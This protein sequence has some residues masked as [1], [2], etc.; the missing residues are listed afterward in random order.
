MK[1]LSYSYALI[2]LVF[3]LG[4]SVAASYPAIQGIKIEREHNRAEIRKLDEALRQALIEKN[5]PKLDEL[6]ADDAEI[7]TIHNGVMSKQQWLKEIE[8]GLINHDAF[9]N[10]SHTEFQGLKMSNVVK[11]SGEFWGVRAKNYAIE[12]SIRAVVDDNGYKIKC[13]TGKEI[14]AKS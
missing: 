1:K 3:G 12:L 11:V 5:M 9:S 7:Y 14:D 6:L 2:S 10:N 8:T 13:I 4:V